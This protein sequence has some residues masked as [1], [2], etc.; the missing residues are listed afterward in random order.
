RIAPVDTLAV[1]IEHLHGAERRLERLREPQLDLPGR[2]VNR[3]ADRGQGMI[4]KGVRVSFREKHQRAR[5]KQ[6][7]SQQTCH[8]NFRK[9][10]CRSSSETDRRG[11][12]AAARSS[13]RRFR[14]DG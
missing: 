2:S 9:S 6:Q 5:A 12:S 1:W 8:V 7:K 14:F 13:R 4:Q 11:K 10:V 3:A